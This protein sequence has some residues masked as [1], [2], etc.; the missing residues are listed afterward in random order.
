MALANGATLILARQ[1]TLSSAPE[2]LH[3]LHEQQITNVTLPPSVLAVLPSRAPA[4]ARNHH[5]RWRSLPRRAGAALGSGT[6][7]LSTPT[8]PPK[9]PSVPPCT[10]ATQPKQTIPPI[11]RPLDNFQLYVLDGNQQ[12]VPVGVP[13]ELCVAGVGLARGYHNRPE[14][15]AAKF[16]DLRLDTP[17]H[18]QSKIANPKIVQNRRPGALPG[19]WQPRIPGAARPSG[20]GARLPH[21]AGRNRERPATARGH[22][23][24]GGGGP[25]A[26]SRQTA[27]GLHRA[28][29]RKQPQPFPSCGPTC[30]RV[31][32]STWCRASL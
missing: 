10:A 16:I 22:T 21:R 27:G 15:T 23:G 4:P 19:R 32:P 6:G 24:S 18:R 31:C 13:G 2:L 20:E 3:L 30:G 14:L 26:R 11:G 7:L 25:R 29:A 1:E 5:R 9:P 12:P 17:A 28:H 8:A